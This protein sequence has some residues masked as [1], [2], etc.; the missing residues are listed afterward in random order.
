M[1]YIADLHVHSHYSRATSRTLNLET[2]H[3]WATIKG[4]HV[5]GT[6]DFTHPKWLQELQEKLISDGNGFYKLK[7]PPPRLMSVQPID[8][9][10][11]LSTEVSCIYKDANKLRKNH[12]LLFAPDLETVAKINTK[13]SKIGNLAADGRPIL[14]LSARN[15]LE[16]VLEASDRA[17]LI[18]AHIWTP[19]FSVLGSKA[20]YDSVEMCFKELTPYIF[21]LETGLSSDPAMNRRLSALDRYTMV[22]NSDAHSPKNLGREANIFDTACTYD[23]LFEALKTQKGFLGTFEFFPQEGKYYLDGHRNCGICFDPSMTLA[24]HGIC[25][26]CGKPLTIGVLH[27]V[28]DLA[29]REQP[30]SPT[31]TT[32]FEYIIPLPEIIAEI[33]GIGVASKKVQKQF[34]HI[35]K[36]FGNEFTFLQ[37]TPI[38]DIKQQAGPIYAE[39]ISRL[40]KQQVLR[41]PGYDG[42]YGTIHLFQPEELK[43]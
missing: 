8:I 39:A 11:C 37:E 10:F 31:D 29:D 23:A 40:R 27:R 32:G 26:I 33:N 9:R 43:R 5:V 6:G 4:I 24:H 13:L 17:Y 2:L 7:N 18:P 14:G 36:T 12:S 19:W 1:R 28:V 42:V 35:I 25:P 16:I 21:A 34:A 3:Q 22:S 41:Q 30:I 15:L 38:Q 20:G